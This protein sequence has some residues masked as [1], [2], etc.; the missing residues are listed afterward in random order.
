MQKQS[1]T[2]NNQDQT[3]ERKKYIWVYTG[4]PVVNKWLLLT[5]EHYLVFK[6]YFSATI[7]VTVSKLFK[8]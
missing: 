8:G 5:N 2:Q 3:E 6:H 7:N 4:Y 1:P